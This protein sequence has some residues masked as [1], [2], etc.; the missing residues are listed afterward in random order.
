[1]SSCYDKWVDGKKLVDKI[2]H[3]ITLLDA[4]AEVNAKDNRGF[5]AL[6]RAAEMG[7]EAIV[8]LLLEH[9]ADKSIQAE[10]YTALSLA[11]SRENKAIVKLLK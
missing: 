3:T 5:T 8:A 1:M 10:G 2:K 11:E 4:N 6:H 7:H 9:G